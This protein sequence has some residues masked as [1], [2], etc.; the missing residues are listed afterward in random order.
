MEVIGVLKVK[1]ET[2]TFGDK[3]FRKRQLVV[4]TTDQYPQHISIELIQDN[5]DLI[6]AYNIGDSIK[7]SINI[8]GREWINPQGE[9]KYFNSVTG[10]RIEKFDVDTQNVPSQPQPVSNEVDNDLPF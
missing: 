4:T 8:G 7:V 5:V 9:A 3:G 6:D 1:G 10:W 2:Q